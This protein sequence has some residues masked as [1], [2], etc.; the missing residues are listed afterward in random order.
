MTSAETDAAVETPAEAVAA[1]KNPRKQPFPRGFL[2][3]I[4]TGWADRP[5]SLPTARPQAAFAA[6]R[7][8]AVSAAFPGKRLVIPAGSCQRVSPCTREMRRS[9]SG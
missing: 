6:T 9:C 7:R 5:E 4:S 8:A 2:D 3:T 1:E